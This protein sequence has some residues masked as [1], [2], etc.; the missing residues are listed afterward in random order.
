MA[1]FVAAGGEGCCDSKDRKSN[2]SSATVLG[3]SVGGVVVI[4][5]EAEGEVGEKRAVCGA[6]EGCW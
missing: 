6:E 4:S 5:V 3:E 2:S 1:G